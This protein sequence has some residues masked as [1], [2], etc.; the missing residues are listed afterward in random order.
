MGLIRIIKINC[1]C[2]QLINSIKQKKQKK[3]KQNIP[4]TSNVISLKKISDMSRY[5]AEATRVPGAGE[6]PG[7]SRGRGLFPV[8]LLV[9]GEG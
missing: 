4:N 6:I 5:C 8:T 9:A 1:I 7:K 3:Q 2:I